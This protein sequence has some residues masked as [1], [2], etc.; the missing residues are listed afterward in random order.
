ML[1]VKLV[2]YHFLLGHS[3]GLL[4]YREGQVLLF[5]VFSLLGKAQVVLFHRRYP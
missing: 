3:Q 4:I 5:S 1:I 2:E